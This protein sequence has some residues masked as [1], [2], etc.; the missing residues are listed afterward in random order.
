[1]RL[2]LNS[3]KCGLLVHLGVTVN[4]KRLQAVQSDATLLGAMLFPGPVLKQAW[5]DPCDDLS[6][7]V[8]RLSELG[9]HDK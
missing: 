1:M 5:A 7:A 6:R 9:S 8:K 3:S 4:D 2:I